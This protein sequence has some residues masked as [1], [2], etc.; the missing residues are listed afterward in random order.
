M[1]TKKRKKTELKNSFFKIYLANHVAVVQ[2]RSSYR[3]L[4][5]VHS[6]HQNEGNLSSLWIWSW[7]GYCWSQM[8]D[9]SVSKTVDLR[10]SHTTAS[11]NNLST[12]GSYTLS[13]N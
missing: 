7:H 13:S 3:A 11:I 12:I 4:G 10:M 9:L 5:N 6:R 8:A 2:C 1:W